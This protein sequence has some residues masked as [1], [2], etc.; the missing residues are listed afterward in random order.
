MSKTLIVTLDAIETITKTAEV[1]VQV[2]DSISNQEVE[3]LVRG[4]DCEHR[5]GP[6]WVTDYQDFEVHAAKVTEQIEGCG[7]PDVVIKRIG[8]EFVAGVE[9]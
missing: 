8:E 6:D 3:D 5:L 2:P 7:R 9:E 4:L 1:V